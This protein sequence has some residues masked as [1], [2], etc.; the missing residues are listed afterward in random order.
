MDIYESLKHKEN[1]DL[2]Y[3]LEKVLRFF[4]KMGHDINL[5]VADEKYLKEFFL[6]QLLDIMRSSIY[7]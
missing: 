6:Q 1:D 7:T 5:N 2:K 3:H 4:E